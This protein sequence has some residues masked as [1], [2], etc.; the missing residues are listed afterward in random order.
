MWQA[1][2]F[3]LIIDTFGIKVTDIANIPHLKT[4]IKE[5]YKVAVD[6]T[7]LL[8]CGVKLSWDYE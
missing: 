5:Y 1:I 8:F 6:W 3:C 4:S 7:E 2:T